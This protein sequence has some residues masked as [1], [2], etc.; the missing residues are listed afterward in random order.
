[1]RA[2]FCAILFLILSVGG[3]RAADVVWEETLRDGAL[4]VGWTAEDVSFPTAAGG[5][6]HFTDIDSVLTTPVFDGSA[7]QS[8]SLTFAVAKF[9][10]GADG[11]ITV[12]Y[13][14]DGG[15]SWIPAGVSPVPTSSTYLS[16]E[17]LFGQSSATMQIRFTRPDSPSAKRLRDV[18]L[19]GFP[20]V[21]PP[22]FGEP[23][24]ETVSPES[25]GVSVSFDPG[26]ALD[27][28]DYGF[29]FSEFALYPEP[30]PGSEGTTVLI[31][32]SGNPGASFSALLADLSPGVVYAVRPFAEY[33]DGV[34]LGEVTLLRTL[35][36]APVLTADAP[37]V[38]DFAFFDSE[39]T[40][41][42]GWSVE[43]PNVSYFGDW[44]TGA[45]SGL[46]G[47]ADILGYQ[48]TANG[49]SIEK[50]LTLANG[51]GDLLSSVTISYIGRAERLDQ[52]G[53]LPAY[54]VFVNGVE[55]P[56][57]AY[58][59]AD[60]D[61]IAISAT[62][63]GLS[64]APGETFT[65]VW[66]ALYPAGSGPARQIGISAVSV[67][68]AE[69]V[70]LSPV[71][72]TPDTGTYFEPVEVILFTPDTD[73]TIHYTLDGT[74][75]TEASPVYSVPFLISASAEVRA[76]AFPVAPTG[77]ETLAPVTSRS[78]VLPVDLPNLS[79][80]ASAEIGGLYRITGEV[81]LTAAIVFRNQAFVQDAGAGVQIDDVA[82][83]LSARENYELGDGLTGLVGT[84]GEFGNMLRL[85]PTGVLPT[86]TGMGLLPVPIDL[87]IAD[88][89][90]DFPSYRSRLVRL[91]DVSFDA[92]DGSASFANGQVYAI[93]DPSGS[94]SFRTTFFTADTDYIGQPL[95]MGAGS[96][97][98][99]PNSRTDGDFVTARFL[100]DFDFPQALS[101]L[102]NFLAG[103]GITG[104]D[105]DPFASLGGDGLTNVQKWVFGGHPLQGDL[106]NLP[107]SGT[108]VGQD[109]LTYAT[110]AVYLAVDATWDPV[111]TRFL[112]DGATID[113]LQADDD[114]SIFT[115]AEVFL[116]SGEVS[117]SPAESIPGG[118]WVLLQS[119]L[120][121]ED[122]PIFF[123]T[124]VDVP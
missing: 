6:A 103:F 15:M 70:F 62:V 25:L 13:S 82:G 28:G 53:R 72:I 98:V 12:D 34:A 17:L 105:A 74:D 58:S 54:E 104:E 121:L 16:A 99:I 109:S 23:V 40:L 60:G 57:L 26:G 67:Q 112:A 46:R 93:T 66:R 116:L 37:Y 52:T 68:R 7:F 50:I 80:L 110:L 108:I 84:L 56:D 22:V 45:S 78:Y 81:V 73:V 91:T 14:I 21:L 115:S 41:P 113:I 51:T 10:S 43:G 33:E 35:T 61:G 24:L 32:G 86:V 107:V 11:P 8:F 3:L 75:P 102:Q 19:V 95:P 27:M 71:A 5:Y 101:P 39:F 119:A 69:G 77:E 18:V 117:W 97:V 44:G 79:A 2:L 31:V 106:A 85:V 94:G 89:Y 114:L 87:T 122:G 20:D 65:I 42:D 48:L 4:P 55:A 96:L 76:R 123:R 47:D 30:S 120:P 9:G 59:T 49:N 111:N 124:A 90:A 92:A 36:L 29:V 1:M 63:G 38:E 100:A 83:F 64:V 88:L 118:N